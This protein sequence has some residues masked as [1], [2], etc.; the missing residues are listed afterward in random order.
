[1]VF[2]A[3]NF[4]FIGS[5]L[6]FVSIVAGKTGYR[7]GVPSLLLFLVVGMLFGSDGFGVQ[8][9]SFKQAQFIGMAALSVILFSGGMDTKVDEIKPVAI[10][11]VVLST[12]G[13]IFTT[14]ITGAFIYLFAVLY[15]TIISLPLSGCFLL[16]A[17]MSSTD[18]ASV[19][20]ILRSRNLHLTQNVRPLLELESGSN[21][22]M[23]YMLTIMLIELIQLNTVSIDVVLWTLVIQFV[24]GLVFGYLLG[25][26]AVLIINHINLDYSSLYSVLLLSFVLFTFSFTNM[27]QGNGYLAVY[28]AGL[29][30]GNHKM[31][32]KKSVITFFDGVA[33]LF[34]IVM[35]LTLGLLVNP[36]EL[37]GVAFIALAIGFFMI[38]AARPI[39][40]FLCLLPFK[41]M[42]CRAKIFVS[43]VGLRGAVPIIF[44]T[45]PYVEGVPGAR[46]IF[47]IVFFIT[48]ISLVVQGTTVSYSARLLG[49][50]TPEADRKEFAVEMPE[51]IA[52]TSELSVT[53]SLLSNG[54]KLGDILLPDDTLVM[55]IKREEKFFIPNNKTELN[56]GDKLLIIAGKEEE[57]QEA[58]SRLGIDHYAIYKS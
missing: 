16:A 10:Q 49:L 26:L 55:M 11:G 23:A 46:H 52:V 34:Q 47:N 44:A 57:M 56:I 54:N 8:F 30:V 51:D 24:I 37:V 29:V 39:S 53:E 17:V 22:P 32:Y 58:Y 20:S 38:I 36:R 50:V 45:Y 41:N 14:L 1:M 6:L 3:E 27:M 12:F 43:W 7:F 9:S 4:L 18:S 15:P 35:F 19:F 48:I 28:I 21:D 31:M 33:W 13:V 40:V 25:R 42:S 2:S 5:I